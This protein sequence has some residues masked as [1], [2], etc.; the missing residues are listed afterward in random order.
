MWALLGAMD[1][2]IR[3]FLKRM[4]GKTPVGEG[5]F[6]FHRGRI[7]GEEVLVGKTGVGKALSALTTQKIIDAYSPHG[8]IYT[9]LAGSLKPEMAVGDTLFARDCVQWDLDARIF[10]FKRGK[11][12]Y[13]SYRFI[14]GDPDLL[15]AASTYEPETG[16]AHFGRILTGDTFVK[17]SGSDNFTF[18]REEL[19]GWAVEMEGASA[20][21][22]AAVNNIPFLLIRII[23][24]KADG[25]APLSFVKVVKKAS[26]LGCDAAV[27][28]MGHAAGF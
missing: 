10:G 5:H 4:E 27:H 8:I 16:A 1:I 11:I 6:R 25:L 19:G 12:P 22:T 7:S 17:E 14:Q 9:G 23:S 15:E 26:K 2:E 20:A 18:L 28:V 13:T 3:E 24:D 21:L